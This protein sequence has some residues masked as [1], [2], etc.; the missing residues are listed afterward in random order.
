MPDANFS[1]GTASTGSGVARANMTAR[2]WSVGGSVDMRAVYGLNMAG[3]TWVPRG[4]NALT[5]YQGNQDYG[6]FDM[7]AYFDQH[8]TPEFTID[9][10]QR[11]EFSFYSG[12][13]RCIVYAVLVFYNANG[14][15][16]AASV[17]DERAMN[18]SIALGGANLNAWKR[19]GGFARA[20]NDAVSARLVMR[21]GATTPG[22]T[23]SWLMGTRPMVS[24]ASDYQ[25]VFSPWASNDAMTMVTPQGIDTPSLSAISSVIGLMRTAV[26]GA[27]T[28]IESNLTRVYDANNVL[29]VRMGVW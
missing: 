9:P 5:I 26:S 27:R 19:I 7:F 4:G 16:T 29:R 17:V 6:G 14:V 18:R 2:G 11:Y 1:F 23:N 24:L 12:A 3:A 21:K 25:D 13:H 10:G 20:P 8:V 22:Q 15:T 28:E